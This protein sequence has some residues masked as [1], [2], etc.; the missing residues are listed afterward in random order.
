MA[1]YRQPV[2]E[3]REPMPR[4][5]KTGSARSPAPIHRKPMARNN[6]RPGARG[7]SRY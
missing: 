6:T 1:A 7:T 3:P 2:R 4:K 5:G